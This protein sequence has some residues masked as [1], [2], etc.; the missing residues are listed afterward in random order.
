MRTT[1]LRPI[2]SMGGV[3]VADSLL[4]LVVVV[5]VGDDPPLMWA[6]GLYTGLVAGSV[7]YLLVA[8]R[9]MVTS[10]VAWRRALSREYLGS[11]EMLLSAMGRFDWALFAWASAY[12]SAAVVTI[13]RGAGPVFF[14]VFLAV[15]ASR[16]P[17][18]RYRRMTTESYLYI[19]LAFTGLAFVTAAP[20]EETVDGGPFWIQAVGLLLAFAC[21]A[22]RGLSAFNLSW[23][24][25]THEALAGTA[26]H[27]GLSPT[28]KARA[29]AGATIWGTTLANL[30]VVIVLWILALTIPS[31][32]SSPSSIGIA[33]AAGVGLN[34]PGLILFR[35]ANLATDNLGINAL[36]Y[37]TPVVTLGLLA[38]AGRLGDVRAPYVVIG[39]AAIVTTNLFLNFDPE[40]RLG[41]NRDIG[42]KSF[43][44]GLWLFG[45]FVFL[46][47]E[48]LPTALLSW[49]GG[50]YWGMAAILTTMFTLLF[51]FRVTRTQDLIA[52]EV[53]DTSKLFRKAELLVR[54]G[55][56]HPLVLRCIAGIDATTRPELLAR[57][58]LRFKRAVDR[59]W[60]SADAY[61]TS[62]L[63][64]LESGM[65]VLVQSKQRASGFG[66]R[67]AITALGVSTIIFL[68]TTRPEADMWSGVVIESA[69][70]LLS[71]V[72]L[73]LLAQMSD[74]KRERT[75]PYRTRDTEHSSYHLMF[76]A[77]RRPVLEEA[78]SALVAI[79]MA[80]AF[81][82]IL[83]HKWFA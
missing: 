66:E 8:H 24:F 1:A 16:A 34:A 27:G 79:A 40:Q 2:T 47:D 42:F 12:I 59:A 62:D 23:G 7:A 19:L 80:A 17:R 69:A 61:N 18:K 4:A 41:F 82:G 63:A 77:N 55:T 78:V 73:F 33:F 72:L 28:L 64:E 35:R 51:A 39:V 83:W 70:I 30:P 5:S 68:L 11:R 54:R 65:D 29:E 52:S 13:I 71:T 26:E 48:W 50:E 9:T 32:H 21:A 75:V 45:T 76:H 14:V 36:G 53:R 38:V 3:I 10:R 37:L 74:L 67:S 31:A 57:L 44:I 43:V 81:A 46:R 22:A 6:A 58:Y 49:G 20:G 15:S 56:L 60:D 25:K